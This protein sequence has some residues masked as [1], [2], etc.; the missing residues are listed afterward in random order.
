MYQISWKSAQW[1][2]ICTMRADGRADRYDE[3]VVAFHRPEALTNNQEVHDGA[4][5]NQHS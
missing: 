5:H 1:W 3:A 4:D 2:S